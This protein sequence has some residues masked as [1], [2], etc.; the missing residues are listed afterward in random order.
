M[1]LGVSAL[2]VYIRSIFV[3]LTVQR[4]PLNVTA[5]VRASRRGST[6]PY[7]TL[8][9]KSP[10]MAGSLHSEGPLARLCGARDFRS[11]LGAGCFWATLY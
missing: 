4:F 5:E 7:R 8:C 2:T 9:G 6:S 10:P 11:G 3:L 1:K